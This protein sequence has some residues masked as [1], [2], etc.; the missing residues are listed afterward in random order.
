LPSNELLAGPWENASVVRVTEDIALVNTLDFFT[1]IVDEPEIQGRIA[2]SNVTSDV[3]T[4]AVTKIASMLSILA[5]PENMPNELAVGIL[6]GFSDFCKE[7]D[8]PLLGGHT[9]RNPWPII[10]G[11]ASGVA[12][13]KKIVYIRGAKPGD[14]LI[15]TKPIGIQPAMAAYRMIKEEEGKKFLQDLSADL[16][17]TAIKGAIKVMTASNKAVAEI[18]Q[19][20]T[21]NAA[22]DITGFGL[23]G[24]AENMAKLSKVD[25]VI[26]KLAV[27]KGTPALANLLGYSLIT[28]EASE[29]AGGILISASKDN[30]NEL[31]NQLE[32]RGIKHFEVGY[33]KSGTG[34]AYVKREIEV[35]ED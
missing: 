3:Y 21:V 31:I 18:M 15:L 26:N 1:P 22:T 23:K 33:V 8:I 17:D 30:I 27:I 12:D 7:M 32:E 25:I 14:K 11:S 29:T 34:K 4:M 6:K 35:I 24:H 28:G 9:I 20:A 2:A 5:F 16:I 13:P 10:G 19:E